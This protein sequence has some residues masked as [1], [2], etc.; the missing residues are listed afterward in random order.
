MTWVQIFFASQDLRSEGPTRL[1]AQV[2]WVILCSMVQI[3]IFLTP[4]FNFDSSFRCCPLC[5]DDG[6]ILG[7]F[8]QATISNSF[9]EKPLLL[10]FYLTSGEKVTQT[11]LRS[12]YRGLFSASVAG[13]H[14][15]RKWCRREN[16]FWKITKFDPTIHFLSV[17]FVESNGCIIESP[18]ALNSV[19]KVSAQRLL[20]PNLST[21]LKLSNI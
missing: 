19:V 15:D 9:E 16:I 13:K 14:V 11:V 2:R 8:G 17:S 10:F 20:N 7:I 12:F 6:F 3:L 1:E 21:F 4:V 18:F 5:E